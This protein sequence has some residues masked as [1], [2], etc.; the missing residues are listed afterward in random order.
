LDVRRKRHYDRTPPASY[1]LEPPHAEFISGTQSQDVDCIQINND[2]L[3]Q[4]KP[5]KELLT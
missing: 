4:R 1:P 3:I 5:I 2:R